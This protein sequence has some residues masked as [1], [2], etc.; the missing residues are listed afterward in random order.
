MSTISCREARFLFIRYTHLPL[1]ST[2]R[3]ITTVVEL[4]GSA[5]S[6][7]L[8]WSETSAKGAGRWPLPP[9]KRRSENR[10]AR[11]SFA[12]ILPSTKQ[13][14]STTLLLPEPFGPTMAVKPFER[15]MLTFEFPNDLK[16]RSSILL[17]YVTFPTLGGLST[18]LLVSLHKLFYFPHLSLKIFRFWVFRRFLWRFGKKTGNLG[19]KALTNFL[20]ALL[21]HP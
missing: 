19:K 1:R 5:L 2:F 9:L 17:T 11:M 20:V 15:G 10:S 8:K 12:L 7:L 21:G 6:S 14:P 16:P 13:S 3:D 4:M 18:L